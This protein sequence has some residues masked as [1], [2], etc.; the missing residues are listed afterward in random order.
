MNLDA[1]MDDF[2]RDL[3]RAADR[4]PRRARRRLLIAVPAA[5]GL[6]AVGVVL[7]PRGDGIDAIAEARQALAPGN[8]IVHMV[9]QFKSPERG[10]GVALPRTEQWY[11]TG[12][13]RWRTRTQ[14]GARGNQ[15]EQIVSKDRVRLYDKRR[16]VVRIFTGV[17][18]AGAVGP[19]LTGGDP[20]T[21]L[22]MEL[23]AG[24][25][26]D[27][28]IVTHDGRQVHRLVRDQKVGRGPGTQ[29]FVYYMDPQTFAPLGGRMYFDFAKNRRTVAEFTISGYERIPLNAESRKLLQFDKTP[30]TRYV[31]RDVTRP[32]RSSSVRRSARRQG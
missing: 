23:A 25:V 3:H 31:W 12:P 13:D 6:A 1:F 8:E 32:A 26:R 15:F 29:R 11:A 20:A 21:E 10:P 19:G 2:G 22:R 28:G 16:D 4:P 14:V 30:D 7:L 9:I 27:D 24:D 18:L 17:K 5:T